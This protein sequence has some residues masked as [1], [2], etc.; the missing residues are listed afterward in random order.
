M[1][2]PDDVTHY[3]RTQYELEEFLLFCIVV[4][5]KRAFIQA[6][7]LENWIT[8]WEFSRP[9]E[10]PFEM[11]RR[12]ALS[13]IGGMK[14]DGTYLNQTCLE[15]SL[16]RHGMGQYSRLVPCFTKLANS[17]LDLRT[18]T[19]EDLEKIKGIG[20]KTSRF[21]ILHSRENQRFAVLDTHILSWMRD[22][23]I[24]TPRATPNGKKYT[25]LEKTFLKLCDDRK[26]DPASLDLKVWIEKRKKLE[27]KS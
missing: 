7:K 17:G 18:C 10:L 20:P 14:A 11:I 3:R 21:F 27:L 19:P 12:L 24:K 5:G 9:K 4:A 8:D 6:Q 23:G 22:L 25:D 15:M 1:V 16:K 26:T 2:D 13:G